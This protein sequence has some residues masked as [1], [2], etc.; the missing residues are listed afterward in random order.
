MLEYI[1]AGQYQVLKFI[2]KASRTIFALAL[3]STI[4]K[5]ISNPSDVDKWRRLLFMPKICLKAPPREGQQKKTSFATVV[6][7]QIGN[8]WQN[9]Q[10][11]SLLGAHIARKFYKKKKGSARL[12]LISSKIDKGNIQG[13]V[14]IASPA[15]NM[16]PPNIRSLE[17]LNMKH[18]EAPNDRRPFSTPGDDID[19]LQMSIEIV[20]HAI[21][22]FEPQ[23]PGGP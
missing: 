20:R 18:P 7:R 3:S 10:L 15:E 9:E 19:P 11:A 14:R 5:I 6:N 22:S 1:R 2:P 21:N 23:L 4:S 12:N 8:F 16:E 17:V 13:A